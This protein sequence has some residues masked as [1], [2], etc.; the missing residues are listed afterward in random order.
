MG[1]IKNWMTQG[2]PGFTKA[3]FVPERCFSMAQSPAPGG[4]AADFHTGCDGN[5]F[6]I[7]VV[8][9]AKGHIFGGVSAVDWGT[10]ND[11]SGWAGTSEEFLFCIRC[12]GT[13]AKDGDGNPIPELL[14]F[15]GAAYGSVWQRHR[16][17]RRP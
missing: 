5:Q 12:A 14:A 10:T 8:K 3:A 6:T 4:K 17:S 13:T 7:T 9:T 2:M 15:T 11:N 1:V 16:H